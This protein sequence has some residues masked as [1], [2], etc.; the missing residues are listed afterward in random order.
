MDVR[1]KG[2]MFGIELSCP[3]R[4]IVETALL[5]GVLVNCT[6]SNILRIMPALN[7]EPK[8]LKKGLSI[9][10]EILEDEFSNTQ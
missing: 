7:I 10:E 9:L 5:R 8:Y 3:C 6:H 4:R 1:G 2:Y